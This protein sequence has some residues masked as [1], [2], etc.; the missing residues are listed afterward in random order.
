MSTDRAPQPTE[1]VR[2]F[3]RSQGRNGTITKMSLIL[4]EQLANRLT[5]TGVPGN[6]LLVMHDIMMG[7]LTDGDGN[8]AYYGFSVIEP[9]LRLRAA[10][11]LSSHLV[12]TLAA[13]QLTGPGDK[14]LFSARAEAIKAS[15]MEPEFRRACEVIEI[16]T[17]AKLVEQ[18]EKENS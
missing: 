11:R 17:A 4:K 5:E 18:R 3:M 6:P 9:A 15:A 1:L 12:P 10:E 16:V 8:R 14:P 2:P 13:T 7:F